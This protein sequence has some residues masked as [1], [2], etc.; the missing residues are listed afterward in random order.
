MG[1]E[2]KFR[3]VVGLVKS[4]L[5]DSTGTDAVGVTNN[6]LDVNA[7]VSPGGLDTPFHEHGSLTGTFNVEATIITHTVAGGKTFIITGLNFVGEADGEFIVYIDTVKVLV[8][9]NSA[10]NRSV[11]LTVGDDNLVATTG[12]TIEIKV[13]NISHRENSAIFESTLIGGII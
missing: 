2:I 6:R 1:K 10:A 13:T 3:R 12:Q 9:R 11:Y 5:F 7:T 4:A 8:V